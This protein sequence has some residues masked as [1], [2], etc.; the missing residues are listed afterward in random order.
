MWC[1]DGVGDVLSE[2]EVFGIVERIERSLK[3]EVCYGFRGVDW[4]S[5]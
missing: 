1:F 2:Y 3:W 4:D 5:L